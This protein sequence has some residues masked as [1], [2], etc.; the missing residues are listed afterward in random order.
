MKL[1]DYIDFHSIFE[2]VKENH[3]KHYPNKE[4]YIDLLM[5]MEVPY[6]FVEDMYT[7]LLNPPEDIELA[8]DRFDDEVIV[9]DE[10]ELVIEWT[11]GGNNSTESG[12]DLWGYGWEF[13]ID[14]E[15][16]IFID[17]KFHNYS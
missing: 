6:D 16:E 8:D 13:T 5:D 11:I 12:D 14:L 3:L 1:I 9:V 4:D 7:F 2:K 10:N 15:D 17:F